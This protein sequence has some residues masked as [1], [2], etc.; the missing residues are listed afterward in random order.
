MAVLLDRAA[1]DQ[2]DRG[3]HWL[4]EQRGQGHYHHVPGRGSRRSAL[5]LPWPYS[6]LPVQCLPVH[7]KV[8][9]LLL[10]LQ[11]KSRIL[12]QDMIPPS[13]A[14]FQADAIREFSLP[15]PDWPGK[16]VRLWPI[17]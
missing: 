11:L 2:D 12:R 13:A 15:G 8:L 14:V 1:R 5:Q 9:L 6:I 17:R 7:E 4:Y 3:L 16:P 10:H